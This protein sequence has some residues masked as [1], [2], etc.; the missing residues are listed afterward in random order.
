M[1]AIVNITALPAD[2]VRSCG[3]T[4]CGGNASSLVSVVAAPRFGGATGRNG[5][6]IAQPVLVV[7]SCGD[8]AAEVRRILAAEF[9]R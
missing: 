8:H 9:S 1:A 3:A 2:Q 7:P 6:R 5:E 4:A